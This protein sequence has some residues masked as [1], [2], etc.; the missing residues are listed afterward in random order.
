MSKSTLITNL[1][2]QFISR[3]CSLFLGHRTSFF[4][5]NN[6]VLRDTIHSPRFLLVLWFTH[7]K[8]CDITPERIKKGGTSSIGSERHQQLICPLFLAYGSRSVT[9]W[10]DK[11]SVTVVKHNETTTASLVNIF[12]QTR[13]R[14][15]RKGAQF[16]IFRILDFL[17]SHVFSC[18]MLKLTK[19]I[20]FVLLNQELNLLSCTMSTCLLAI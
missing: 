18:L 15:Q 9:P 17:F 20:N 7:T 19:T 3:I 14:D 8:Q 5:Q 6:Q 12:R 16:F 13:L 1:T 4:S 10:M 2:S 11:G